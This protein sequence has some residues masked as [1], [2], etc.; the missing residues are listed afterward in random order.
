MEHIELRFAGG[1]NK[2]S[3]PWAIAGVVGSGNLEVM[4]EQ[5]LSD[6]G[7][8]VVVDTAVKGFREVWQAVLQRFVAR[9]GIGGIHI[10]INDGGATPAVVALR[11][12][13]ALAKFKQ[14]SHE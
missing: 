7:T 2:G 12:D 1:T 14:E 4:I 8:F 5:A 11:L 3:L 10:S 6:S 13:Q 9:H